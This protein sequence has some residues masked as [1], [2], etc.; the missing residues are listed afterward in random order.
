MHSKSSIMGFLA[1]LLTVFTL[2]GTTMALPT[3]TSSNLNSR[4]NN[5]DLRSLSK[6]QSVVAG[7]VCATVPIRV[8]VA[9]VPY[10]LINGICLCTEAGV[11]TPDSVARL[12]TQIVAGDSV[13][14]GVVGTVANLVGGLAN[15]LGLARTSGQNGPATQTTEHAA[16]HT[17]LLQPNNASPVSPHDD[18]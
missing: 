14:G 16:P 11:L 1:C 8:T 17:V 4:S 7:T 15:L 9:L 2:F 10:T 5:N 18:P 12:D 13:V 3:S 6:R